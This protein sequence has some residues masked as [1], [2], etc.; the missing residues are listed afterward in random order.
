M[1]QRIAEQEGLVAVVHPG[2]KR[3][4]FKRPV[5]RVRAAT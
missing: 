2:Y 4:E 3:L 5:P 1:L